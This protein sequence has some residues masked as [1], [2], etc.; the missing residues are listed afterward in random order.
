MKYGEMYPEIYYDLRL[1]TTQDLRTEANA[2]RF[3]NL[4]KNFGYPFMPDS[5][6]NPEKPR[7]VKFDPRMDL[8]LAIEVWKADML[9]MWLRKPGDKHGLSLSSWRMYPWYVCQELPFIRVSVDSELIDSCEKAESV[10]G[11]AR[12][13]YPL[14]G[15]AYGYIKHYQIQENPPPQAPVTVSIPDIYWVNFFGMPYVRMFGRDRLMIAPC[16]RIEELPDGGVMLMLTPTLAESITTEGRAQAQAVKEHLGE[17]YFFLRRT[18]YDSK[19][20]TY[21][22]R[23]VPDFDMSRIPSRVVVYETID[24]YQEYTPNPEEFICLLPKLLGALR[25][26]IG[27]SEERLD[28]S[29]ASLAVL[30]RYLSEKWEETSSLDFWGSVDLTRELIAYAGEVIR[31]ELHGQWTVRTVEDGIQAGVVEVPG[32]QAAF[33]PVIEVSEIL[34]EGIYYGELF[35]AKLG[36]WLDNGKSREAWIDDV[37]DAANNKKKL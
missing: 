30:D 34:T 25:R 1:S 13:L 7:P 19:E 18:D 16:H 20:N 26:R 31:R 4:L 24:P 27:A 14:A 32:V 36:Y 37:L 12:E 28:C 9:D 11:L 15:A 8:E 33:D 6:M 10:I 17:E 5:W 29:R 2:R 22:Q 3:F 21:V 23:P 35:A